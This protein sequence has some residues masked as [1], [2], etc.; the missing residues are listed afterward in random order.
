MVKILVWSNNNP[1]FHTAWPNNVPNGVQKNISSYSKIYVARNI[2][3]TLIEQIAYVLL[4]YLTQSNHPSIPQLWTN[5]LKFV[6][7]I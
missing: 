3:P 7:T 2:D 1:S 6:T 5:S 4:T